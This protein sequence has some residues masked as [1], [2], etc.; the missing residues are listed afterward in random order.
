MADQ[1]THETLQH[2]H[3][4]R[5][6]VANIELTPP[7]APRV[8]TAAYR[9]AHHLLIDEKDSPCK[10][11]GVRKSTLNDPN[12]NPVGAKAL[13]TH[14][15]PIE[16]SLVDACDWRKVHAVYPSV[17]SQETLMSWVDSPENLIT[18]CDVHHR[19]KQFGI[20]HLLAQDFSILPFLR[21]G[22]II[23]ADSQDAS[24]ARTRDATVVPNIPR[25]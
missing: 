12:A 3:E 23:A 8:E 19:S 9:A 24:A 14:H 17:Y 4:T 18:L 22:Y 5:E 16:R 15:Y 2:V 21:D 25:E 7:H 6:D 1:D 20:H 13:E 11:C 10:V